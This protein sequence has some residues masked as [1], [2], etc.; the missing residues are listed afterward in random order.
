MK[1]GQQ[2][3]VY[4]SHWQVKTVWKAVNVGHRRLFVSNDEQIVKISNTSL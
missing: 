1:Q 3:C 2:R 4:C